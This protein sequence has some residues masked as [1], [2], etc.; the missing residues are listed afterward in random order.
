MTAALLPARVRGPYDRTATPLFTSKDVT[1]VGPD[2][3]CRI[4]E[5]GGMSAETSDRR[6][7]RF[8]G[9]IQPAPA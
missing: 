4:V 5:C 7:P 3:R 6:K 8:L 1:L 9:K 2:L